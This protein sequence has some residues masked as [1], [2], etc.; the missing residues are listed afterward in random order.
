MARGN[1]TRAGLRRQCPCGCGRSTATFTGCHP[2]GRTTGGS[3]GDLPEG[4]AGSQRRSSCAPV[5]PPPEDHSDCT[6]PVQGL[7]RGEHHSTGDGGSPERTIH[8]A[9][10]GALEGS[11]GWHNPLRPHLH[12]QA[13]TLA[14][15]GSRTGLSHDRW[16]GNACAAGRSIPA[17]LER[18]HGGSGR[19]DAPG[20]TPEPQ[21]S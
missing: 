17:P 15:A 19:R 12:T 1:R 13:D 9:G 5:R 14:E 3:P 16:A 10:S 7:P 6:R 20:S 21:F 8:A 2:C 4:S 18:P 11:Q